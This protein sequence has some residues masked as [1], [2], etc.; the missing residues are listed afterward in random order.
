MIIIQNKYRNKI[1]IVDDIKFSSK[2]EANYYGKLKLLLKSGDVISFER[3]V[4]YHFELNGVK[5]GYYVADFVIN[6]KTTGIRVVDVKG[7]RLPIYNLK[8]K[9]MKAFHNIDVIEV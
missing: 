3:Q 5:I 8:K 4:K 6:W 1:T 7:M 2:K 9:M